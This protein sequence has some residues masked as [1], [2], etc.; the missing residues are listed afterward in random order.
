[1]PAMIDILAVDFVH[2][3]TGS[4][5]VQQLEAVQTTATEPS[6]VIAAHLITVVQTTSTLISI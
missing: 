1:M 2:T 5:V 3:F 6:I 4:A